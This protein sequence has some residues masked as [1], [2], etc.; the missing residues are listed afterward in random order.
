MHTHCGRQA[1]DRFLRAQ[2]LHKVAVVLDI[3]ELVEL[4]ANHHVHGATRHDGL[5]AWRLGEDFKAE[6]R[7]VL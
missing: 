3:A 4:K 2:L 5:E 6:L 7:I 1:L